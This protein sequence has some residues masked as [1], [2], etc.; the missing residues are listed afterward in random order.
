M[1][2]CRRFE[3]QLQASKHDG[4][5]DRIGM[6]PSHCP[7]GEHCLGEWHGKAAFDN[8]RVIG[9]SQTLDHG[10]ESCRPPFSLC[11]LVVVSESL[12]LT[13]AP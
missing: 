3:R 9:R 13:T 1:H 10:C 8:G 11:H 12:S 2:P 5:I 4:V 6:N 7:L